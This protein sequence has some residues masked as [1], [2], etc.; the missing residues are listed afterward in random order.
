MRE[1]EVIEILLAMSLNYPG[2]LF[3]QSTEC[4]ILFFFYPEFPCGRTACRLQFNPSY[5]WMVSS[6]ICSPPFFF[7]WHFCPSVRLGPLGVPPTP[8]CPVVVATLHHFTDAWTRTPSA[9]VFGLIPHVHFLPGGFHPLPAP[10]PEK[11]QPDLWPQ[12][13]PRHAPP[14]CHQTKLLLP[15]ST[16]HWKKMH[17]LKAENYILL[18]GHSED[19][20]PRNSLS[21]SSEEVL[22]RNEGGIR[23]YRN[24]CNKDQ[25]VRTSEDYC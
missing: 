4:L 8:A 16:V 2:T 23:I 10:T 9:M 15:K 13:Y 20:K 24:V 17:N 5:N 1:S 14:P 21:D 18:C 19:F 7:F 11:L 6:T 3:I 12:G 22:W 25:V